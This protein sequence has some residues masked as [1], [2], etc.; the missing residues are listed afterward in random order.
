[1]EKLTRSHIYRILP[2]G[3]DLLYDI[4]LLLP[5]Y[6]PTNIFDVGANVGQS[7]RQ[8]VERFPKAQ[9]FCF[10]PVSSI[11]TKLQKNMANFDNIN[12]YR[13]AF[14]NV[15]GR[16][17]IHCENTRSTIHPLCLD[18]M[19]YITENVEYIELDTIDEF[20]HRENIRKIGILKIDTEGHDLKVLRGAENMLNVHLIDIVQVEA[21][22][23]PLS[24][25]FVPFEEFKNYL[26]SRGYYLFGIYEQV[27]E[28]Y[29]GEPHLRRINP[30]FISK[31]VID[32]NRTR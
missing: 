10:E 9:V 11:F 4:T 1:M 26:E 18:E 3:V 19:P 14:S 16:A 20:C 24:S 7:S 17:D 13:L 32:M 12:F 27:N 6:I 21:G 5:R 25:K 30:V 15:K 23:N 31:S 22:M 2:R 29:T 8:F 28:H